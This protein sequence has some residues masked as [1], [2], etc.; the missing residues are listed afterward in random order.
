[1]LLQQQTMS[2]KFLRFGDGLPSYWT[3]PTAP[4]VKGTPLGLMFHTF[5]GASNEALN[6]A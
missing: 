4:K 1:V 5:I 3:D 6:L 2:S